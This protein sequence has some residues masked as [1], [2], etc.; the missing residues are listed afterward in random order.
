MANA[1]LSREIHNDCDLLI[2]V[3]QAKHSLVPDIN[4]KS[5][6]FSI[7]ITNYMQDCKLKRPTTHITND[8]S[9]KWKN[10][11]FIN[12][13]HQQAGRHTE[14]YHFLLS[15][16]L[17]HHCLF[18]C[19]FFASPKRH[20]WVGRGMMKNETLYLLLP[21]CCCT[22]RINMTWEN[23]SHCMMLF[24]LWWNSRYLSALIAL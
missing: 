22:T 5:F 23:G 21:C 14:N 11:L 10:S 4:R 20:E 2:N 13:N 1:K 3:T 7:N 18:F 17:Q 24:L 15:P 12:H 9:K 19:A 8:V 16:H 6:F